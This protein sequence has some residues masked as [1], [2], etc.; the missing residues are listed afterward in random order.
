MI[1]TCTNCHTRFYLDP[2]LL[3]PEGKRVRCGECHYEWYQQPDEEEEG[4]DAPSFRQVLSDAEDDSDAIDEQD[5]DSEIAWDDA[6][7]HAEDEEDEDG[8]EGLTDPLPQAI[9]PERDVQD[10]QVR[11]DK[12]SIASARRAAYL[13]AAVVFILCCASAFIFQAAIMKA[14]PPS[15]ALYNTLGLGPA[16]PGDGLVFERLGAA[17][18]G[19]EIEVSGRIINRFQ[20]DKPLPAVLVVLHAKDST[21]VHRFMI[22]FDDAV[23]P[24]EAIQEFKSK[25]EH[26]PAE[27]HSAEFRFA[28]SE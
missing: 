28:L 26:I 22:T 9:L 6:Q 21:V 12:A 16:V 24:G 15:F 3:E 8:Q 18:S 10:T 23:I 20:E 25:V 5:D 13:M 27:T 14:W 1:L 19:D 17:L 11:L 7:D 4:E 2:Y